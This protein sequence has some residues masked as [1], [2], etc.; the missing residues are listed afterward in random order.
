[1]IDKYEIVY[2]YSNDYSEEHNIVEYFDGS[3]IELKE[4][5]KQMRRNGCYNISCAYL[6][7]YNEVLGE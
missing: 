5:L 2:D 7:S 3:H 1:M 6:Y 4:Y